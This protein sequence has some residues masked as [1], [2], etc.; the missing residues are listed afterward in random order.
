MYFEEVKLG[1]AVEIAPVV[2]EKVNYYEEI[3]RN[4]N[5]RPHRCIS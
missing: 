2:I 5:A 1:M 3:I 4:I